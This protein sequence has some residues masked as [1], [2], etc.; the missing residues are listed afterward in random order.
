M[1]IP[2]LISSIERSQRQFACLGESV[3]FSCAVHG[4]ELIW[5]KDSETVAFFTED[6]SIGDGFP[7]SDACFLYSA[8]LDGIQEVNPGSYIMYSTL[9]ITPGNLND[10]LTL[11]QS[12]DLTNTSSTVSCSVSSNI[13]R[14]NQP[15]PRWSTTYNIAGKDM[16][17]IVNKQYKSNKSI[18][19]VIAKLLWHIGVPSTPGPEAGTKCTFTVHSY[20]HNRCTNRQQY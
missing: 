5:S 13:H 16:I 9:T 15:V 14:M 7:M 17:I 12:C 18:L 1:Q 3:S 20:S 6:N 4:P 8:V 19:S 10:N 11:V 2:Y